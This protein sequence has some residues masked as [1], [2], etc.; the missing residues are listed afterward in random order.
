VEQAAGRSQLDTSWGVSLLAVAVAK[1]FSSAADLP[2]CPIHSRTR[3]P[4]GHAM[5]QHQRM[6]CFVLISFLS[7]CKALGNH[8]LLWPSHLVACH[9]QQVVFEPGTRGSSL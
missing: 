5:W 8:V 2:V 9:P 4:A 1:R 3:Q 7:E 6:G